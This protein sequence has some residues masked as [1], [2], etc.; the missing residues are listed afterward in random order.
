M[1]GSD[2]F[3]TRLAAAGAI[4]GGRARLQSIHWVGAVGA[5]TITLTNGNG[6]TTLASFD[7]P[8]GVTTS[9]QIYIGEDSGILAITSLY[10]SVMSA[11]FAT[12]IYSGVK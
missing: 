11:A 6:G 8:A 3:A 5:G 7:I 10:C 9:G 12:F 1:A 2:S 4:S